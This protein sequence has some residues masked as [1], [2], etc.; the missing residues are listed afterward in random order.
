MRFLGIDPSL[1][2]TGVAVLDC[3]GGRWSG[4]TWS[5]GRPGKRGEPLTARNQ[6]IGGIVADL[7]SV[8]LWSVD[9]AAV[10]EPAH[11]A[12]GGSTWDRAGLWW[13]IVHR[14]LAYDIPVVQ[15]NSSQRQK[16]AVGHAHSKRNPVDKS[17][18]AMA[19][20]KMWPDVPIRGNNAA[21]ALVI[22]S[23]A[24]ALD[25]PAVPFRL[26]EYRMDVLDK[27]RTRE[28]A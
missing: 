5:T 8:D 4:R 17:D 14:L 18:V 23:V 7:L 6:R 13:A 28:A 21:D 2:G 11:G 16:F 27:I 15:V 1:T 24:A 26:T 12:P 25:G 19:A 10:E 20:A 3:E 22:A 9:H